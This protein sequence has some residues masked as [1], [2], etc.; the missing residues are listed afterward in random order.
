MRYQEACQQIYLVFVARLWGPYLLYYT[1]ASKLMILCVHRW[2]SSFTPKLINTPHYRRIPAFSFFTIVLY[3][4]INR[5]LH[6][7]IPRAADKR[8]D[9][10]VPIFEVFADTAK[11]DKVLACLVHKPCK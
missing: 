5:W 6:T 11:W 7:R 2:Q 3:F 9:N 4:W 1:N 10:F 8:F